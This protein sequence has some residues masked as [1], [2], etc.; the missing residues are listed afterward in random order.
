[1]WL[2][3]PLASSPIRD[4]KR[5]IEEMV[6]D[7]MGK[8]ALELDGVGLTIG[9]RRILDDICWSIPT[10]SQAA[11]LGPN[12][13]GKS[14][15]LRLITGYL[16]ATDGSVECLGHR[17]G[18]VS[19]HEL[20]RFVGLVD[21]GNPFPFDERLTVLEVVLTGFFGIL[22]LDFDEP[23]AAQIEE[24]RRALADVGLSGHEGQRFYTLSTGEQRRVLLA[25]ALANQPRLLILDEPTAGLDLLAR[26][27][28]LATI[29]RLTRQDRDLTILMVTHHLEELLPETQHVLLLGQGRAVAVGTPA[30]VLTPAHLE[31]VFG[32]PVRV[33]QRHGRWTWS[34]EPRVWKQ[35]LHQAN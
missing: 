10:G 9:G 2:L 30:E 14:S 22:C 29:D 35:L 27:T 23:N 11:I 21:P 19:V 4:R 15:L 12:G 26:E 34:V 20:R 5:A 17:L 3:E 25:R 28:L 31:A 33:E 24:G 16:F 32:C 7:F 1:L 13:S 18:T 8:L 6:E